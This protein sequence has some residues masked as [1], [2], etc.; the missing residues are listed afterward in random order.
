MKTCSCCF[1]EKPVAA[2]YRNSKQGDGYRSEC[3]DCNKVKTKKRQDERNLQKFLDIP[4]LNGE[5][6]EEVKEYPGILWISNLGRAKTMI[7]KG[8]GGLLNTRFNKG[9]YSII[10]VQV[11]GKK[12][13]L[14]LHRLI[15][16]AFISNPNNYKMVDHINRDKT[17][18]RTD[19]LRWASG[20]LNGMN[21]ASPGGICESPIRGCLYYKVYW[22]NMAGAQTKRFKTKEQAE[23]FYEA[24]V[25]PELEIKEGILTSN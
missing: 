25:K 19:N 14:L 3:K 8:G 20:K 1:F 11:D 4:S 6:W 24:V 15:A 23:F 5:I 9:G 18:N 17:D 10:E 21:R 22:S 13:P 7:R 16:K 2:Y 12:K